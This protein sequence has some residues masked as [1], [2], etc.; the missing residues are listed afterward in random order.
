M[1]LRT[2]VS[3]RSEVEAAWERLRGAVVRPSRAPEATPRGR[4]R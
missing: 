4:L 3:W 2:T 1:D